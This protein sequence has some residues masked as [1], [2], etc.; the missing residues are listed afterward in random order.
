MLNTRVAIRFLSYASIGA[1]GTAAQFLTLILCVRLGWCNAVYGT[2]AGGIVG[3]GVN[4]ILNRRITFRTNSSHLATLPKFLATAC[5]GVVV[6][7]LMMNAL[8]G[9]GHLNYVI[10]QIVVSATVLL[11]TFLINSVWTFGTQRRD[12]GVR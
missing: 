1:I 4:Y 7:G 10:S 2:M 8:T 11:L 12:F 6:S 3:A 5:L 9:I